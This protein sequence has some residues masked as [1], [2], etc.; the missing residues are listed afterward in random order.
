[1]MKVPMN[2]VLGAAAVTL[3][4]FATAAGAQVRLTVAD[5]ERSFPECGGMF[6][7]EDVDTITRGATDPREGFEAWRAER[8]SL[9]EEPPTTVCRSVV[10]RSVQ[11]AAERSKR[12]Y[13]AAPDEGPW[14]GLLAAKSAGISQN[15]VAASGITAYQGETT[16]AVNP[17]NPLQLVAGANTFYRDPAPEC[18]SPTGGAANTYGT[19][20]LYGSK[21]GGKTWTH[22]CAPWSSSLTGGQVGANVFFGSDPALAWDAGG[23]AYAAY[24]LLSMNDNVNPPKVG[25]A[26]VLAKSSD[27][28][29][30]WT[31]LGTVVDNLA[32]TTKFDDKEMIA[33]DTSTGG[34]FSH[35]GRIYVIWDQ[36]NKERVAFS[37]DGVSWTTKLLS[38]PGIHVGADVK[39]GPDGTV[40]AVWN[41]VFAPD[42]AGQAQSDKTFFSKST[43]GGDTWSPG[44]LILTHTWG[45]FQTYYNPAPQNERGVNSFLSLDVHRNPAS[46]NFGKLHVAWTDATTTCCPLNSYRLDVYSSFSSDGGANWSTRLR[47][48]DDPSGPVST[49]MFPWLAV[50]QS[51]GSVNV[52]WYDNRND[53][54]DSEQVQVFYSRSVNGGVSFEPNV[55]LM[56][57]GVNFLN[58]VNTSDENSFSNLKV[59]PNQYGDY[60]GVAAANRKVFAVTTDSRQFYPAHTTSTLKEDVAAVVLTNCSPPLF[61]H[62]APTTN[63]SGT[64]VFLDW[65]AANL[66]IN[67]TA[68]TY[69]VKRYSGTS[70]AGLGTTVPVPPN[71]TS[72][73]DAPL[74]SGTYSYRVTSKNNCPG[75]ALTPMT[76]TS[77]CSQSIVKP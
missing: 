31:P 74:A 49:H 36:N 23:N 1:M 51:D 35:P 50:D 32:S 58:A 18:Q 33:I 48:N 8:L 42:A 68:V 59:N 30:T 37:D 40:F 44:Q 29:Q 45:S 47:V 10:W 72:V 56:D 34:A 22:R 5:V 75:T 2:L 57:N 54:I 17:N 7:Q 3:C 70:C 26:I 46:P 15:Y 66:G 19:Q 12:A 13:A 4:V 11:P 53:P 55:N 21:D 14:R 9:V 52:A 65:P 60:M 63:L 62:I 20:A 16:V 6:T 24:M 61:P 38:A 64:G 39:V 71:V 73:L 25:V 28:G 77:A 41:Q 76:S 67:A 69:T 27:A 43:D